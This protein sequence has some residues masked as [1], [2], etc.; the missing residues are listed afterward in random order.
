MFKKTWVIVLFAVILLVLAGGFYAYQK[1]YLKQQPK[2]DWEKLLTFSIKDKNLSPDAAA[3]FQKRFDET[4]EILQKDPDTFD[5][6]IY[7]GVLKKGVNDYEGARDVWVYAG[8]IRPKSSPPFANLADLYANFLN[9]P[10]KAKEAIETAIAND[11]EDYNFYV[12]LA[13]LYRYKLSGQEKLYEKTMLEAIAKFPDNANLIGPLA[14]YYRETGQV[15]KAIE[16]Y[17]KLLVLSPNN[18]MAKQDLAELKE[19]IK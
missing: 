8:R 19:R 17:E 16:Y 5:S 10:Q 9:D 6:W 12:A 11:P 15:A 2:S 3:I 14:V 18:A 13:E 7:L 4:K 1:G